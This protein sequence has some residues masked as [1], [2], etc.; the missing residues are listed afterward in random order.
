MILG[1]PGIG[2]SRLLRELKSRLSQEGNVGWAVGRCLSYGREM[3]YHLLSSLVGSLLDVP[4][5]DDPEAVAKAVEARAEDLLGSEASAASDLAELAGSV[6]N[7]QQGD[8]ERRNAYRQALTAL[9]R[10]RATDHDPLVVVCED[11]HWADPSS[12]EVLGDL[13]RG[14]HEAGVLM[15]LTSRLDRTSA[16][17]EA[18]Q[19]ARQHLGEA[20]T[21]L[22]L[23]PLQQDHARELVSHL[24]EVEALPDDLRA[25]VLDKA[26][27]NPFFVEEV[28]RMLIDRGAIEQHGDRW[29]AT[30]KMLTIDVPDS[31]EAL[32]ASRVDRLPDGARQIARV[33]SVI[34]RR[35]A[36]GLLEE[37]LADQGEEAASVHSGL[38]ELEAHGLI[39]LAGTRPQLE[40]SFRHAL[41]QEV[42]YSSLLHRERRELHRQVGE[43]LER[44]HPDNPGELAAILGHHF[45]EAGD[46]RA[47]GY[48]M[49]AGR[50]ALARFAN[51]EAFSFFERA[52]RCMTEDA[53]DEVR[54]DRVE[55]ALGRDRAGLIFVPYGQ[56]L[57][58]LGEA[59]PD[60]EA[61]GDPV[62]LVK[63]HLA[64]VRSRLEGGESYETSAELRS[65]LDEAFR[66]ADTLDDPELRALPAAH[67]GDV[68]FYHG[69]PEGALELWSEAI[70]ALE[71][72]ALCVEAAQYASM[73]SRAH[74]IL[75]R[76]GEAERC[77]ASA[78]E[79]AERSGDPNSL[80]DVDIFEAWMEADRGD[81]VRAQEFTTRAIAAADEQGN[82]ACSLLGNLL[83]GSQQL[84]LGDPGSAITHLER[85]SEM[86]AYC[87][88]GSDL[89]ALGRAWLADAR[90]RLGTPSLHEFD[91][92][93]AAAREV[94]NPLNEGQILRQQATVR[95]LLDDPDWDAAMAEF[96]AAEALFDK[97][98]ARAYLAP[99]LRDHAAALE[100]AGEPEE[101]KT[102]LK[103]AERLFSEMGID[104]TT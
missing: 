51:R 91:D 22:P 95:L 86:A 3:P 63:V 18:I 64:L 71:E 69:D 9:I 20:L 83:A 34:G 77:L 35:F 29:T 21:E 103:N 40:Y 48:L 88:V 14:G 24:L 60:A 17:W 67:M 75:G 55:A 94:R 79:F 78:R 23:S 72:A 59:L 4:D 27:G 101:A 37:L 19:A 44:G 6:D 53:D 85:G 5:H 16:G 11:V 89:L 81:L 15:I 74:S 96:E 73:S 57:T 45:D 28:V 25:L 49:E 12:A 26:E 38:G 30:Q 102:R 90:T 58:I 54:R 47:G 32:I 99:T 36:D 87:E 68:R 41:V 46:P 50:R 80:L 70:P 82:L 42:V 39:R 10:A 65:S 56:H 13:L 2:K 33:A 8:I 93:L 104:P 52:T 31:V 62:L 98:G 100:L 43:A 97:I 84:R 7:R 1:E 61:L 76:F 92:A 66:L